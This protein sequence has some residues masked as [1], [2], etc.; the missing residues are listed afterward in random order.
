MST[1]LLDLFDHKAVGIA[2]IV[3]PH[4]EERK[5]ADPKVYKSY[6]F[7]DKTVLLTNNVVRD[8][9]SRRTGKVFK[10]KEAGQ[11]QL[12]DGRLVIYN[13]GDLCEVTQEWNINH[14]NSPNSTF[15]LDHRSLPV[16]A[17]QANVD[18][19]FYAG[20]IL[21]LFPNTRLEKF[22]LDTYV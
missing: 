5:T 1:P 2:T 17:A 14:I 20:L 21:K 22:I 19:D 12:L 15:E 10:Y 8:F 11:T 13:K 18:V 3:K 6:P 16:L 7:L 4:L 9:L